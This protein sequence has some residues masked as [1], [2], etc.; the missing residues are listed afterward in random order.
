M[1]AWDLDP[2]RAV[3]DA[4]VVYRWQE[5]EAGRDGAL[6]Q[7]EIR[8]DSRQSSTATDF[9]LAVCL[10]VDIDGT[11]FFERDWHEVIPRNLV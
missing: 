1:T 9:D 7:I 2:G 8:A 10:E 3:M 6:T 4:H 11:R 5:R